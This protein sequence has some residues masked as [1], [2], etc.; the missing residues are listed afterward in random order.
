MKNIFWA[1][2]ILTALAA[3]QKP[4]ESLLTRLK[5]ADNIELT[6]FAEGGKSATMVL[7]DASILDSLAPLVSETPSEALKCGYDGQISY[8]KGDSVIFSG[9]FNLAPEC[10]HIAYEDDSKTEFRKLSP[11]PMGTLARMK[12]AQNASK[13][14]KLFWFLG[15][16][17]QT[18]GPD[19]VSYEEW[20][21]S[22]DHLFTGKAWTVYHTDTVHSE[23]IELLWEGDDIFYIPT[24]PENKGPVRFKMTQN[25]GQSAVFENPEHDFPTKISYENRGDTMLFAKI[26][27][28][29]KGKE[30]AKEFP[31][32]R[33]QK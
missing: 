26:S 23:T 21:R 32:V 33:A 12:A 11:L 14:E 19:L 18:E 25:D 13:L 3:C 9:E 17:T 31:L 8:R 29:I 7:A 4:Q 27:G 20:K 5:T 22:S 2:L 10:G 24:V 28:L 15:R 6:F 1:A 30:V 16:W